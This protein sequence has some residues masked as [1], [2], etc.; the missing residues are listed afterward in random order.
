VNKEKNLLG[1][2]IEI[3]NELLIT[4]T[5]KEVSKVLKKEVAIIIEILIKQTQGFQ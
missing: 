4:F 5:Y 2:I 3:I 1:G